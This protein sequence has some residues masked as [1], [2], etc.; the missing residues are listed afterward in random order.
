MIRAAI[1]KSFVSRYFSDVLGFVVVVVL[2]RL[3]TPKEIGLFSVAFVFVVVAHTVRNFGITQ[4]VM[5]CAE[6]SDGI[7]RSATFMSFLLGWFAAAIVFATSGL[8]ADYYGETDLELV[9]EILSLIFVLIP[10]S[11][12]TSAYF[13]RKLEYQPIFVAN[14]TSAIGQTAT[15]LA[16]AWAGYSYFSMAW[17]A[18]VGTLLNV[19][20]VAW[21]H[22][23]K[24][25]RAWGIS[26]IREVFGFGVWLFFSSI[27]EAVQR[28]VPDLILG[29]TMSMEAV[30][31]F[32]RAFGLVHLFHRA[33]LLP[34]GPLVIPIFARARRE[35][36]DSAARLYIRATAMITG[37]A[38]PFYAGLAMYALPVTRLLYGDQWDASVPLTQALCAWG[39][40][41]AVCAFA[42]QV[43]VS[44]GAV[45]TTFIL[46][47]LTFP[48]VIVLVFC[49]THF[50][51][52]GAAIGFAAAGVVELIATSVFLKRVTGTSLLHVIK[53]TTGSLVVT[54]FSCLGPA[55]LRY[56]ES[57]LET[58]PYLGFAVFT[59]MA[60]WYIGLVIVRHPLQEE[61][62]R[63]AGLFLLKTG[64]LRPRHD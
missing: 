11:S 4:Y 9:L 23:R 28:G 56:G 39:A 37:L 17:G 61:V 64:M 26:H 12:V 15:T 57:E 33:V 34:L 58:M 24:L 31:L 44:E 20:V 48:S 51:L 3:L 27:L 42:R 29:K 62:K 10:F 16:L 32:S 43:L 45:K 21:A 2:A 14:L 63:I 8:V 59:G 50:G 53:G 22:P 35:S 13:L 25:P 7:I 30:G 41:G 54:I 49:G 47:V 60:G 38:W 6:I 36:P 18:V 46:T 19:V 52:Q 5:Q 55:A 1:F 40:F